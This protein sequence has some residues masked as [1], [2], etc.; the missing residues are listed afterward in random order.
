ME[1][2]TATRV[3]RCRRGPHCPAE[4][5]RSPARLRALKRLWQELAVYVDRL[6]LRLQLHAHVRGRRTDH[7]TLVAPAEAGLRKFLAHS[8]IELGQ[9]VAVCIDCLPLC[10][11]LSWH[12]WPLH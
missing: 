6:V 4:A 2:G 3:V 12:A 11:Q 10:L 9:E 1:G 5:R 7:A 8:R